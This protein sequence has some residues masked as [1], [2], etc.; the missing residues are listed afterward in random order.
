[1]SFQ[2][3]DFIQD[4][5]NEVRKT[6]LAQAHQNSLRS[7]LLRDPAKEL[8]RIKTADQWLKGDAGKPI[9]RKL[10]GTLWYEHELCI[11][12]A[13]T[14]VGKSILAVQIGYHLAKQSSIHPLGSEVTEPLK[15]LY[16]DF[17]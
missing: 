2:P 11:L 3:P 12:F 8:F 10:L 9:P 4:I 5:R 14:N 7:Q 15:V 17:E 13:D 1:M 6:T 16:I